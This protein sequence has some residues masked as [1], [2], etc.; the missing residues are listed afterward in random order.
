MEAPTEQFRSYLAGRGMP[1]TKERQEVVE[2]I[3]RLCGPSIDID[4][5]LKATG[6]NNSRLVYETIDLLLDSG[7]LPPSGRNYRSQRLAISPP[8][9]AASPLSVDSFKDD[10]WHVSLVPS[11]GVRGLIEVAHST[12][13]PLG[14]IRS[15]G[16]R[17]VAIRFRPPGQSPGETTPT[18]EENCGQRPRPPMPTWWVGIPAM[19]CSCGVND[20]DT[21]VVVAYG[22]LASV[23]RK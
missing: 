21:T 8:P 19:S 3:F 18:H 13:P 5:V 20:C 17:R 22:H 1:L 14:R 2:A 23:R 7:L 15:A 4:V 16:L 10:R 12:V 9:T 11:G 6:G